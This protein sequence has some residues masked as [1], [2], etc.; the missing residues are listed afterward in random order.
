LFLAKPGCQKPADSNSIDGLSFQS[1]VEHLH[2]N[3]QTPVCLLL[4]D[5]RRGPTPRLISP[6]L[7]FA[8]SGPF[9]G[10]V[11]DIA[12]ARCFD[13]FEFMTFGTHTEDTGDEF[14]YTI[15]SLY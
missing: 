6:G 15:R 13:E 10:P 11:D 7:V 12:V 5:G 2:S 1:S 3:F 9:G 8:G 4:K 14:I